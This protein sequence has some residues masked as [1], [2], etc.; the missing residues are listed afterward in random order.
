[1]FLKMVKE[2]Y[3]CKLKKKYGHSQ[4]SKRYEKLN[5]M[6]EIY[7]IILKYII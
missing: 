1:M 6:A 4:S 3:I 2:T 5:E 7:D